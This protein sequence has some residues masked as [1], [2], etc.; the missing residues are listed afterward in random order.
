MEDLRD[1]TDLR[2]EI[3]VIALRLS[4]ERGDI[5]W[6]VGILT[7]AHRLKSTVQLL[8]PDN[9]VLSTEWVE[10][11]AALHAALV[12]G[13]GSKR[14]LAL[15]ASLYEQSER[16]RGLSVGVERSRDVIAEHQA[17]VDAALARDAIK[18]VD[19]AQA[20]L[21]QTTALI[22]SKMNGA[23]IDHKEYLPPARKRNRSLKK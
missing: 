10:R 11:H 12:A 22:I 18:L 19:L 1:L 16:Y 9:P 14:L 5:D 6:E 21:R 8:N 3:E 2:C 15:H 4:V 17:L 20:H 23:T 13:C 7:A